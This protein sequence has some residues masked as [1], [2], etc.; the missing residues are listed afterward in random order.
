MDKKMLLEKMQMPK[1]AGEDDEMLAFDEADMGNEG[2]APASAVDLAS[3]SDDE[4]M[5]EVKKRGLSMEGAP[6]MS[7]ESEDEEAEYA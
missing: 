3:V 1:K 6:E 5:M 4:L 7:M 2:E